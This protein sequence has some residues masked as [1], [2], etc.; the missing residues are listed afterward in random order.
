MQFEKSKLD[1]ITTLKNLPTLPHILLKLMEACNKERGS[2]KEVSSIAEKDPSISVQ[3]L[4]LTN[5]GYYGPSNKVENIEKAVTLVGTNAVRNI[6][7]CGSAYEAFNKDKNDKFFNL[8][9]FWWH[10]LKCAVLA[11]LISKKI[12]Y[13]QSDEA[14]LAG[15][16]HDIGKLVLWINFPEPYESLLEMYSEHEDALLGAEK[17]LVAN[18]YEIGA[19]LLRRWCFKPFMSDSVFYHHEPYSRITNALPL[20]QIVYV[21]NAL[22]QVKIQKKQKAFETAREIFQFNVTEVEDLLTVSD[23]ETQEVARSLQIEFEPPE[24]V[25]NHPSKIDLKKKEETIQEIKDVSLL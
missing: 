16:M 23:K 19:W 8:K 4:K 1:Q 15:L 9:L 17:N 14:Y 11:R 12:R 24:K 18:H 22:A 13:N 5:S 6:A 2:L 20:V 10:S 3:I 21:A 7:I 25:R